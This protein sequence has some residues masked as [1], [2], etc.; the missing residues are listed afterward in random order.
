MMCRGCCFP[1]T[2]QLLDHIGRF[3]VRL[4]TRF[5]PQMWLLP[6]TAIISA[7]AGRGVHAAHDL[8]LA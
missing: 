3:T 2:P 4:R 1:G 7:Q 8:Q 6:G 5:P